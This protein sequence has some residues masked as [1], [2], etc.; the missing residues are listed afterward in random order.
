MNK[1]SKMLLSLLFA[2]LIFVNGCDDLNNLTLNVPLAIEFSSVGSN[3]TTS[4]TEYFCLSDYSEWRDNQNDIE[5]AK[6]LKAAYWTLAPGTTS[7]LRGN[8]SVSLYNNNGGVIFTYPLGNILASDYI[9]NPFELEL[10]QTQIAALDA[11]LN[12]MSGNQACF[13]S[14]LNVTNITGD[15]NAQGDFVL[16]GKV[17]I[18]LETEVKTN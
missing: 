10:N 11:V 14:S 5:S 6:Y 16:N 9:D 18:V 3:T 4:D 15:K 1:I 13:S 2:S 7:N 8:V 12:G 17:E